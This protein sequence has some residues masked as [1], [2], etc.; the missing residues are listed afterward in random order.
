MIW[1]YYRDANTNTATGQVSSEDKYNYAPRLVALRQ[2]YTTRNSE[3]LKEFA[4]AEMFEKQRAL[5]AALGP[6]DFHTFTSL[7]STSDYYG[8]EEDY[9]KAQAA[10][11][12]PLIEAYESN[13]IAR[14][15]GGGKSEKS[16]AAS[17]AHW[18]DFTL[19]KPVREILKAPALVAQVQIFPRKPP[20]PDSNVPQK[21]DHILLVKDFHAV[22]GNSRGENYFASTS[23]HS[24]NEGRL[25]LGLQNAVA[26]FDPQHDTW[27]IVKY[28]QHPDA[29]RPPEY[30]PNVTMTHTIPTMAEIL[31]PPGAPF[32]LSGGQLYLSVNGGFDQYDFNTRQWTTLSLPSIQDARLF[33]VNG[34]LFTVNGDSITEITGGGRDSHLLAST[35]RRPAQSLLDTVD[36]FRHPTL[37]AGP[38][39]SLRLALDYGGVFNWNGTDWR[40]E[41]ATHGAADPAGEG[42]FFRSVSGVWL[43]GEAGAA[44][45]YCFDNQ[46]RPKGSIRT[47]PRTNSHNGNPP[48]HLRVSGP[49]PQPTDPI[50]VCAPEEPLTFFPGTAY[51]SNLFF[52][53]GHS[54]WAGRDGYDTKL[55]CLRRGLFE[56]KFVPLK[57]ANL[58][59]EFSPGPGWLQFFGDQLFINRCGRPGVWSIPVADLPSDLPDDTGP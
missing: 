35:R 52:L 56:P 59:K 3:R 49:L 14:A 11:L 37:F 42:M 16:H 27:V 18:V 33:A 17:Y 24:W 44:T 50:W 45:E 5:L 54:G 58:D 34:R 53:V 1:E 7:F 6:F 43:L 39:Q 26:V 47:R 25:L 29:A 40:K 21:P 38:N 9:S 46:W 12:L 15:S 30:L 2:A 23:D 28:P 22:P 51:Q 20:V 4:T 8:K 19:A 41:F 48:S 57:F 13:I 55:V 31:G 36:E 32:A 10:Q